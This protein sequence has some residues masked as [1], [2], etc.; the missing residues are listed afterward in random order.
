MEPTHGAGVSELQLM[1]QVTDGAIG[2]EAGLN[3]E[4][5]QRSHLSAGI[6]GVAMALHQREELII[7][8]TG[9]IERAWPE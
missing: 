9:T 5:L 3:T 7:Q 4:A 1:D 6:G 8:L 2:S